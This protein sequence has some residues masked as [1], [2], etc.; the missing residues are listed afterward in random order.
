MFPLRRAL[1][2]GLLHGGTELLPVS[3]SGH[4]AAVPWLLGSDHAGLDPE[5]R[6]AF[7]VATHAGS[8][9]AWLL[10]RPSH[11]ETEPL[12][13][14]LTTAPAALAG[15]LLERPI[16]RRLG[17]P[18]S[19]AGGLLVGALAMAAADRTPQVR[20]AGDAGPADALGLGIAQACALFPGVSRSGATLAAARLRGFRR[21]DAWRLS[22]QAATPVI[23]GAAGLKLGRLLAHRP[24]RREMTALALGAGASFAA[25]LLAARALRPGDRGWPLGPFAAYRIA[26]ATTILGRLD[27]SS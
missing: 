27:R 25:T 5:L 14:A 24:S 10:S 4:L 21:H 18:A 16:E 26:L 6:K 15:L 9:A 8:A 1:A 13:I 17:T 3:S 20:G 19:I 23:L 12:L 7:E 11:S 2:L 22:E